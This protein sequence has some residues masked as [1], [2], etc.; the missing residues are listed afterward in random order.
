MITQDGKKCETDVVD[1]ETVLGLIQS[2]PSKQ[3]VVFLEKQG[4]TWR[5]KQI[6]SL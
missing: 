5:R 2:V 4:L 3:V 6:K 1:V